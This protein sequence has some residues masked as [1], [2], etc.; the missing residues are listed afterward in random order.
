MQK[1]KMVIPKGRI[2]NKVVNLLNDSGYRIEVDGRIYIP[3]IDD[4]EIEAKIMKPQN[5]P[6]LVELGAHDVGFTGYDWIIETG[7]NVEEILD[8]KF[9]PIKIVAAIPDELLK[10]DLRKKKIIVASEYENIATKFLN[11]NDYDYLLLRTFGATEVFPPEDANMIIDNT[12]TGR[13]LK[14]HNLRIIKILMKS[15]TR[16]IAN[17]EA[18]KDSWKVEKIDEMK[19][20]FQSVLDARERVILEMNVSKDKLENLVRFL[21]AMRSP[22]VAPLYG[23][24]GFAVKIAV[25]RNEVSKLLP[26]LKKNGAT[27]ILEYE[28]TKVVL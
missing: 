24:S 23:E 3:R 12:S 5:I 4:N 26:L 21:P 15:S 18:L 6:K 9:D 20:L 2:Y 7:V 25:K 1:L 13:T 16:F 10:A 11:E 8:L 14:E 28:F 19:M 22:T 27:D 17:K